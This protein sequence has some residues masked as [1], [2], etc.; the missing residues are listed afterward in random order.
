MK[1]VTVSRLQWFADDFDGESV[2]GDPGEIHRHGIPVG[3]RASVGQ[4]QEAGAARPVVLGGFHR[5][6][7]VR[8]SVQVGWKPSGRASP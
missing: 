2:T 3:L 4:V 6:E 1:F 7:G 5:R 8:R